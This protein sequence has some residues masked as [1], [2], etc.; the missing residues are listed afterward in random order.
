M[1]RPLAAPLISLVAGLSLAGLFPFHLPR[2]IL[3]AL[4]AVTVLTIFLKG[5]LP[6]L[7][8]LSLLLFA[9][10][11]YL[12][13]PCLFPRIEPSQIVNYQSDESVIVEGVIDSR[14][15]A[16][17]RG[18]RLYIRAEE[19][20]REKRRTLVSGRLLLTVGE[21]RTTLTTGDRIRF[22]SRIRK[23]RNFGLP[24]EFDYERF[25]AY[26]EVFA[27]AF[28]K[29]P[30]EMILIREG[31]DFRLQRS[32][33]LVAD[34]IGAFI[35]R[36]VPKAEGSILRAL[37]IGDMGC[38]DRATRDAYSR[39]GVNHILSISGFHV[40]V[41]AFFIFQVLMA[42]AKRSEFL[43]LHLHLR[44]M[45]LLLTFP[46]IIFYLFLS[47]AAP[48]TTRS[49]I[50]IGVYILALVVE[51]ETDPV[52][53]LM[54]AAA[55]ILA[56]TPPAL[57]DLSFQLSFLAFWGIVVLTPV[58]AAP[59][60][61]VKEGA[62][63]K[64]LLFCMA[65]A[66][67]TVATLLPVAYYFHRV[68]A[69]GLISNFFIVPLMG[70][71]AV[72]LG[73]AAFPFVWTVP[74][75]ARCLLLAAAYL[76]KLSN[77]VIALLDK[78]PTLPAMSPG[79]I[80]LLLFYLLLVSFTFIRAGKGRMV[81]CGSL[82]L[83]LGGS[84]IYPPEPDA[85]K[86][87]IM[88]FSVGQGEST[89]VTFP[90]GKRMLVDGGGNAREGAQDVGERL[91]APALWKLG[92]K[93]IDYMVL[94]HPHPDHMQGLKYVA[95]NFEVGEFWEGSRTDSRDYHELH[96]ILAERRVPVRMISASSPVVTV[97]EARIEPLS[98][99]GRPAPA[100]QL[101]D[102]DLNDESLV[103]RLVYGKFSMLFTGDIGFETEEELLRHP[104]R[105]GCTIL[106]V[107]HHGSRYSASGAFFGAASPAIALI[108]AGYRN[109]FHLPAREALDALDGL[110]VTIFR[111]DLD[112]TVR[113]VS[114]GSMERPL[115]AKVCG[116][117]H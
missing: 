80:E 60:G 28:I 16:T 10:G 54:L 95:A 101:E 90:D 53:S 63:R 6:F 103:F 82:L 51:R 35:Y 47:G 33:D 14:P 102:A 23:P 48:A 84:A 2:A 87:S 15:E 79:R 59:F 113:L 39:T 5:R 12:L 111:T 75:L 57:F 40:G 36:N 19:V 46:L 83:L 42:V 27:T 97:G 49:V 55:F 92:V 114:D 45:L 44:R 71:G 20:Y 52:D 1:E 86:L 29:T 62:V 107:P 65:S 108:G 112:G 98:P 67:V 41:I 38:V 89:L 116:H 61:G 115:V 76:V 22:A 58:F 105:L 66:G 31:V 77:M 69:T 96:R 78:I 109:S 70:Y 81:C 17:E 24:G 110:G 117:F 94:S 73:F 26:K 37:L 13:E 85:G 34:R 64:L 32:V 8:S 18:G 74:F 3:P 25:L 104:E 11:S 88:F 106:K 100:P 4:L 43:L 91:L 56:L 30:E 7:L 50:M 99:P 9:S 68:S 72:V 21:G 93:R